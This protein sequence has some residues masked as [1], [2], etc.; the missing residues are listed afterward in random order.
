MGVIHSEPRKRDILEKYGL[1]CYALSNHNV[2]QAINQ[3]GYEGPLSIEFEDPE[4]ERE[5]GARE[6]LALVREL[7]LSPSQQFQKQES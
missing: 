2:G 3:V 6:A 4:M 7:D 1:K 5:Q